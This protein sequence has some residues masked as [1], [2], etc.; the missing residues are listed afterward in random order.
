MSL[1]MPNVGA[2]RSLELIV[3]QAAPDN[4]TLHLFSNDVTP[5]V[6][7]DASAYTEVRGGGYAPKTL[8]GNEW[9]ISTGLLPLAEY[10][11]QEFLFSDVPHVH[12]VYG[13]FVLQG[14]TLLWAERFQETQTFLP[15]FRVTGLGDKVIVTLVFTLQQ[16]A[17]V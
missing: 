10:A 16:S 6:T 5:S 11:P 8:D 2:V 14:D 17:E 7:D 3:G 13:Y 15:P 4:L 12:T 9:L 1:V